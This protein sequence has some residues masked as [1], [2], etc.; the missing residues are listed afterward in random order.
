MAQSEETDLKQ[1]RA[2]ALCQLHKDDFLVSFIWKYAENQF[3][4]NICL[5]KAA[6]TEHLSLQGSCAAVLCSQTQGQQLP[7]AGR[8][9]GAENTKK[10]NDSFS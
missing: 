1:G 2:P 8:R 4:I 7:K 6:E 5:V 3:I 9:N 10:R